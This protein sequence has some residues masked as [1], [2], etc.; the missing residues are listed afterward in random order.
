MSSEFETERWLICPVCKEANPAGTLFCRRCWG[1]S[2]NKV[3]PI[4]SEQLARHIRRRQIRSKYLR[5][6]TVVSIGVLTPLLLFLVV[7]LSLYHFTDVIFPPPADLDSNS[8][9]GE[10]TMFR[11][12]LRRSG[13]ADTSSTQP[14]GTLK[15]VFPTGRPIH[16]SPTVVGDT[17]YFGSRDGKLYAVDA[18]T[19][20]QRWEF[21]TGSWVESSPAVSNGVV[22][23][24]SNDS[25]FYALDASTGQKLWEYD[26]LYPVKSSPAVADGMVYFGGWDRYIHALDAVTGAE[27][28][29]LKTG[30]Y[31]SSS[32]A[33]A[34]GILYVGSSDWHFYALQADNGRLR[35]RFKTPR[36][37]LSSPAVS[38][39]TVYFN[40]QGFLFALDGSARNWP[41]EHSI[42]GYWI[43]FYAFSLAPSPPPI[44]GL[45]WAKKLGRE[46]SASPIVADG[47][48]YTSVDDRL[49]F[50]DFE[51]DKIVGWSF[52]TGGT[53]RSSPALGDGV[54]YVGSEDGYLYAVDAT[55]G[56][57]I[58][59]FG[60]EDK[61]TSSPCLA[62]GV[63]YVGSHDGNLYAIE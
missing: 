31:V 1:A 26:T 37:T 7:V 23:F 47:G 4:N 49:C 30:H 22:Y 19:G 45:L 57:E 40:G 35:Y 52:W 38:D 42:R 9:P 56:K 17:V 50:I 11:H 28:W 6:L 24:G 15:W 5:I 63:V 55:S 29:S 46:S 61:I 14:Q 41:G 60:T 58:W 32:P 43:Q 48:L 33:I 3:K 10:W 53:I 51:R 54:V 59:S 20:V 62:D 39:G 27:V 8:P 13:N 18:E 12:D 21:K 44:S 25:R 36:A 16:S 34:E 2:L